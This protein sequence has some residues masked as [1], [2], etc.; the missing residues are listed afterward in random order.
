MRARPLYHPSFCESTRLLLPS[1]L[2]MRHLVF[3]LCAFVL[4]APPLVR[5]AFDGPGS[6]S[7]LDAHRLVVV[8]PADFTP[9][10]G[11]AP[12]P[13]KTKD[14]T[15]PTGAVP[16]TGTL[17]AP[18]KVRFPGRYTLWVRLGIAAGGRPP[19]MTSLHHDAEMLLT[20]SVGQGPGAA[21][22]GGQAGFEAYR[23][24]AA[25]GGVFKDVAVLPDAKSFTAKGKDTDDLDKELRELSREIAGSKSSED[26]ATA[27][28]LEEFQKARPYY[29]WKAG[30]AELAAGSH[31]LRFEVPA[32][33]PADEVLLDAALLTTNDKLLY[34]FNGDIAAPR[35]SYVRFRLDALPKSGAL[36]VASFRV[37]YD[38]F[39]SGRGNLNPDRLSAL[40]SEPHTKTGFTRWYRLQD[41]ERSP[42]FGAGEAHLQLS[43]TPAGKAETKPA[44]A[45]QFAVFPH[46]D[47]VLREIGWEEPEAFTISMAMDYETHLHKLR[48]IR[49]HAREHYE[50]AMRATGERL[51]PL[52]RGDLHFANG[53]GAATGDCADYMNKTL[54]LLG[55]NCVGASAEP[56]KYRELYGWSSQ[57]GHYWPPTFLPFDEAD[58]RRQYEAHYRN[59]FTAQKEFYQG[60]TVFQIADEPGEISRGE[61]CAPLWRFGRDERGERWEDAVGGSDL[62]TRRSDYHDCVL[63][64]KVEQQGR[65]FGFRVGL[66]DAANPQRFAFWHLGAVS[67]N[68]EM[69]LS[70]GRTEKGVATHSEMVRLGAAV[71]PSGTL[72]KIIYHGTSAALYLN[73]KMIQ[74]QDGIAPRGGFGFTGPPK[75]IRELRIRPL[76]KTEFLAALDA[77]AQQKSELADLGLDDAGSKTGPAKAKPLEQFV[78]EDWTPA[79]GMAQAHVAFRKWA[80]AQGVQPAFFGAKSWDEVRPLTVA[81]LVRT[82]EDAR[83][84]YWSRQFSGWVTARMFNLSAEAIHQ[85]APNPQMRGFVALSGHS[86]YFPSEQPLD[87]FQLAAGPAMTPGISDWMSLGSWFWDSHQAVAF[88]IAPYNAGAR[89]YGQEPLNHPMMHCVGPSTLRAYTMLGNN[90]RV[91][92]YWAYGPSYAVTEGYW[93]DSE[94]SYEQAHLINNRAAQVDDI[95]ARSQMRPSRVAMLYSMANE[96]WN[97]QTSFADKRAAFLALSHEYFQPE[98]VTEEQVAA[99]ALQHYDALY[100]L[101]PL[102]ATAAREKVI[103][104][105]QGGGLLW[106]CAEAGS[107]NEFNEPADFIKLLTGIERD[108]SETGAIATKTRVVA[109]GAAGE[110]TAVPVV[111]AEKGQPDFRSHL[112]ATNGLTRVTNH[113][114]ARVRARYDDGSPAW[115]EAAAGKGKVVFL[116]H[117]C[118]LTYTQQK[119]RMAGQHP[120]FADTGRASLTRPLLEAKVERELILSD[121]VVMASPMSSADGTVM[122]LHNMQPTPRRDLKVSLRESAAPH[123]VTAFTG[124]ELRPVP[125]EFRDGRVT[126][127]L[128]E[129]AA[130]QMILVRRKPAPADP[131]L[132]ELRARTEVQLKS[133]DPV[134][135]AAG[136]WTAGFHAGW[137]L[138]DALIPLLSHARWEVRR[139]AAE[140]L[141][142]IGHAPAAAPLR[143]TLEK[144]KDS[145]ALGDAL[146]ALARLRHADAA[147]LCE[148]HATTHRDGYVRRLA[149]EAWRELAWR[150]GQSP[151]AP[152]VDEVYA[153]LATEAAVRALA[154]GDLRVRR[155][156]VALLGRIAPERAVTLASTSGEVAEDPSLRAEWAAVLA[157]NDAAFNAWLKLGRPG[158]MDLLLAVA[159]TRSTPELA[160]ALLPLAGKLDPVHAAAFARAAERQRN[161]ALARALFQQRQTLPPALATHLTTILEHTFDARLGGS[162]AD[163]QQWLKAGG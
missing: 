130:E 65:W 27:D 150:S 139:A 45:S 47:Y 112:V 155:A 95:L 20:T 35:A 127:T 110:K 10:A 5:G 32:G 54:R 61:M 70:I 17:S 57:G 15:F 141:G 138:G 115:L 119:S 90:A 7:P 134:A 9:A 121:P 87:T 37:H 103:A 21:G 99:G 59:F 52:T 80:A 160:A 13:V 86:L 92:S 24:L 157:E 62:H 77:A 125:F 81:S 96:Y 43:V 109:K 163:W 89:R 123:S 98:L 159:G 94:G 154:D 102:V 83:L 48:T 34:P 75:T 12:A 26:W 4:F 126:L 88:S 158:G 44:G 113:A 129:L 93:S 71:S 2:A 116:G 104:F 36:I 72:F 101:D 40:K 149:I 120:I 41:I 67:V 42:A 73:G 152:Q 135:L 142:R 136:A 69:N 132:A 106:A 105:T 74:Q 3:C 79:G 50:F 128:P 23:A 55:M 16:L 137:K 11:K 122:L 1:N 68:R 117:R 91:L 8:R 144:E 31:Q 108:L 25:K 111:S 148:R 66:D 82:P 58:A 46:Q 18:V 78:T 14:T 97:A 133:S 56:V 143:A 84:F 146:V 153:K 151:S 49:D 19:V 39:A 118:G 22:Q 124:G 145:H 63:E 28:R 156:A 33:L 51:Y 30:T 85:F 29:W 6:L 60:T 114:S 38:P 140:A 162:L 100:V 131:R 76:Q 161:P 53:W 64:G 147:A 107:R